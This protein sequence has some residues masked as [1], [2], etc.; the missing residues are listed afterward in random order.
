MRTTR[1]TVRIDAPLETVWRVVTEPGYVK[2]WQYG[3]TLDTDWTVGSRIRFSS[4][5]EGQRFEQWGTVLTV[6]EPHRVIYSLFA[7]RPGLEDRPE[8]YFTMTYE[9]NEDEGGTLLAIVQDDPRPL[10]A[11]EPD[12]SPEGDNPIL[13]ALKQVAESDR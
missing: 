8:N 9:L 12:P 11:D 1:S 4:E 13:L 10:V 2:Q 6:E 3:S 7:P 5:W